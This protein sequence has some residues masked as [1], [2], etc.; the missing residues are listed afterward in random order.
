[1]LI[2]GCWPKPN[3]RSFNG[4]MKAWGGVDVDGRNSWRT[5]RH[6]S[7]GWTLRDTTAASPWT[8]PIGCPP[9][10]PRAHTD[11]S[12]FGVPCRNRSRCNNTISFVS[13]DSDTHNYPRA[14]RVS[15]P[16]GGRPS[17]ILCVTNNNCWDVLYC[18]YSP[19]SHQLVRCAV[20]DVSV[21]NRRL[22]CF[23]DACETD[24]LFLFAVYVCT[25]LLLNIIKYYSR[26]WRHEL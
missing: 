19:R 1:M 7:A 9:H 4:W 22:L 26:L 2:N 14:A 6:A 13:S 8:P 20:A 3:A 12:S 11:A 10:A 24:T 15:C 5:W 25:V 16:S 17:N 21:F 23:C 18:F